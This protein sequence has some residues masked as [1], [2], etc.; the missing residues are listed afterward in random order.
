MFFIFDDTP[1]KSGPKLGEIDRKLKFE[2]PF[3]RP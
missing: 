2:F 1:C 3:F